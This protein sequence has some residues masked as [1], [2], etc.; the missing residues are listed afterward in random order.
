MFQ[1]FL[2]TADLHSFFGFFFVCASLG[3]LRPNPPP[4]RLRDGL[5][6]RFCAGATG[7]S[8]ESTLFTAK[9]EIERKPKGEKYAAVLL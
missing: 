2:V 5:E 1:L 6:V 7:A 4:V 3:G 9:Y 8:A